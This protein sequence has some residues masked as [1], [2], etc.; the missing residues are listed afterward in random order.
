[1]QILPLYASLLAILFV[2]LSIRTI[3]LRRKLQIAVGDQDN[4]EMLRAMRVHSNFSEYV[5]IGLILIYLMETS[6]A[7]PWLIHAIGCSLLIGRLS[8]AYGVSQAKEKFQY[9]VFGM[10]MTFTCILTSAA[11]LLF[12]Y[13]KQFS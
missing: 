3:R 9:R 12:A 7:Y 1:M 6:A 10:A 11:Y 2:V 8:H 5:P 4:L 13:A